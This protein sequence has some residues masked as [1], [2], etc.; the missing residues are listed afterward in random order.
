MI[1]AIDNHGA[2]ITAENAVRGQKYFCPVCNS[3]LTL[4]QGRVKAAHFSHLHIIDCM[5]YL[6]KRESN[7]HLELKHVLYLALTPHYQTAMEFYLHEIEQIADL[8]VNKNRAL[9]IQ[10]SQ[11]SPEL[12]VGRTKGYASLGIAATWLLD[13]A[14]IKSDTNYMYPTHFQL[15]TQSGHRIYTIDLNS[16]AIT[17]WHIGNH[18]GCNKFKYKKEQITPADLI[19]G[20]PAPTRVTNKKLSRHELKNIIAREKSQRT[21]QNPTL[22]FL[23]QSGLKIETLPEYL[24]YSTPNDRFLMNSPLEWKLYIYYHLEQ[25]AFNK[26]RFK[27]MLRPR[28]MFDCPHLDTLS[29]KLIEDYVML[30]N[31]Q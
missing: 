26:T 6:Y 31:S 23:Y 2:Q 12:I 14:A 9:E 4:K 18:M 7:E 11:I 28:I 20:G 29:N 27:E 8:L 5:R 24:T 1:L 17:V 22:T 3:R 15:S 16:H 30:Y 21:V 25:G 13:T 19:T 10:L